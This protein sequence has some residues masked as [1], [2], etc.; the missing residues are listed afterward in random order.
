MKVT[1][2]KDEAQKRSLSIEIIK[3]LF[4]NDLDKGLIQGIIAPNN[5]EAVSFQPNE[6]EELVTELS[7]GKI[8]LANLAEQLNLSVYQ[9]RTVLQYLIKANRIDEELNYSTFITNVT[10]KKAALEKAKEHKRIH[11]LKIK[12]K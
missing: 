8:S 7:N 11:R 6:I 10:A 2:F 12:N 9:V 4:E 3:S 1:Q 5:T